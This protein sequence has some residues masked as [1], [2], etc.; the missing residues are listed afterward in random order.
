[1]ALTVFVI[2]S[3]VPVTAN[4]MNDHNINPLNTAAGH[5][6]ARLQTKLAR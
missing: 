2:L 5:A 6:S 1:L 4:Y 3:F